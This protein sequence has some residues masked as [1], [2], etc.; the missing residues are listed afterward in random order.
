[1]LILCHQVGRALV[2]LLRRHGLLHLTLRAEHYVSS[3]G[4]N[5]K[6]CLRIVLILV[7]FTIQQVSLHIQHALFTY[8]VDC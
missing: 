2:S 5:S 6:F 4:V 7:V 8:Q 1:M 3:Q